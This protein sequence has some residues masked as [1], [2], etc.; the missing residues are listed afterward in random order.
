[1]V[2]REPIGD[3]SPEGAVRE[4]AVQEDERHCG[5]RTKLGDDERAGGEGQAVTPGWCR[6]V[7]DGDRVVAWPAKVSSGQGLGI[8]LG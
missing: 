4:N 2:W 5:R 3:A 1:V 7:H 6:V 8:N